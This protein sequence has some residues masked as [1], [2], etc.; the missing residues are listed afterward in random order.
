MALNAVEAGRGEP[1]VL[2]HGLGS[3]SRVWRPVIDSLAE[4][5]GVLALDFPGF[6]ESAPFAD[7]RTPSVPA[8]ADAIAAELTERGIGQARFAGNSMGGWTALELA[9]RGRAVAVVA[10]SPAGLGRGWE[11][12]WARGSLR[13]TYKSGRLVAKQ[14]DAFMRRRVLKTIGNAQMQGRPWRLDP[15]DAAYALRAL[16]GSHGFFEA[17]AWMAEHTW[18]GMDEIQ[19]PVTVLWGKRDRLLP[20][21]QADRVREF[22]P[23]ATVRKLPGVGHLPMADDPALVAD[24]ILAAVR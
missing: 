6:G 3:S 23:H 17:E 7:D 24:A 16:V 8:L 9:R 18:E 5:F 12:R 13:R 4:H 10:L 2:L 14:A 11:L 19:C 20:P 22:I 1:L 15:A 21:R